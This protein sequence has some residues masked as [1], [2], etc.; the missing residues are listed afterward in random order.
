MSRLGSAAA[1]SVK[2]GVKPKPLDP[3]HLRQELATNGVIL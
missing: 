1:L 3:G 2:K